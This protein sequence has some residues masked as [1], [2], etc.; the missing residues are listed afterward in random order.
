VKDRQREDNGMADNKNDGP[1]IGK[2]PALSSRNV[3]SSIV[4]GVELTKEQTAQIKDVSG[5]DVE[6]LLFHHTTGSPARDIE[7][8]ALSITRITY[9]W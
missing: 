2:A 4:A 5:V 6:W 3:L 9:C 1:K 7:P 8:S